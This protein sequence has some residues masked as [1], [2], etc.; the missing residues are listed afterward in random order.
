MAGNV[1]LCSVGRH[2]RMLTVRPYSPLLPT[3]SLRPLPIEPANDLLSTN[4]HEFSRIWTEFVQFVKIRGHPAGV[5]SPC[6]WRPSP[7]HLS[8]RHLTK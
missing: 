6:H 4:E 5:L 2:N 7:R 3:C 1:L 8:P